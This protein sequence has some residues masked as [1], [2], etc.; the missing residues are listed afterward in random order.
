MSVIE[1]TKDCPSCGQ[2]KTPFKDDN[3]PECLKYWHDQWWI[4]W[5]LGSEHL[6][7]HIE[8]ESH[9]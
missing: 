9:E 4:Q 8:R 7:A 2:T 6:L 5:G 3:C 1:L